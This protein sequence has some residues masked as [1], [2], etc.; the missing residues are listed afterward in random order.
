MRIE[1][2][3][4]ALSLINAKLHEGGKPIASFQLL[5]IKLD[6]Q[7]CFSADDDVAFAPAFFFL[8]C[9]RRKLEMIDA[10]KY[11]RRNTFIV[12]DGNHACR[13]E[14]VGVS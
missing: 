12:A 3:R 2:P 11:S 14:I 5:P 6:L 9:L 13:N 8:A 4:T 1:S 10:L 7:C